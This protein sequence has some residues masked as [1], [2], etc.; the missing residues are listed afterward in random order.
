V[1]GKFGQDVFWNMIRGRYNTPK[2]EK[3][4]FMFLDINSS[5]SIAEQLGDEKYHAFLKDFFADFT[6]PIL[7]NKGS[8]YQ[9]VGDEVVVAWKYKN[10]IENMQCIN[11]FFHI[12]RIRNY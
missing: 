10:G 11:C 7:D 2:Q 1:A 5:T 4:I 6:Y 12:K 3:R 9:Y 8:I